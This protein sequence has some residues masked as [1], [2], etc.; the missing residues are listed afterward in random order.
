MHDYRRNMNIQMVDLKGQYAKIQNEINDAVLDA[1]KG[2]NFINGPQVRNFSEKLSIYLDGVE[3]IP[4]ANGTDALQI[5]MMALSLQPGDEI[6]VPSFTYVATAEVIAL[7][8]L[9]PVLIDVDPFNFNL[10][11]EQ[12]EKAITPKTKAI[13]PVHLFGQC[14]DME[15]ILNIADKHGLFVIEDTAQALGASYF[16]SNG[17]AMKAGT[18]GDIGCTSF[19][20]SKNLGCFGDGG[21]V[22]SRDPLLAKKI[23][24]IAN[25][26]QSEKYVHR[27]IGV[28]SRLDTIQAAVLDVKMNYLDDYNHSRKEA[29]KIYDKLLSDI[30]DVQIPIRSAYSTHVFH[31]Y[32]IQVKNGRRDKLKKHLE[33]NGIPA[34][35]YYPIPL[36]EQEAFSSI[37]KVVSSLETTKNLCE[38]VLSLPM[39][40]ELTE[41]MQQFITNEIKSFLNN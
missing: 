10:D 39:H 8:H 2:A 6:I 30:A 20:P 16:F 26:G 28:N 17:K 4:C 13:V 31:Q 15:S 33:N 19:F 37:C 7:L 21:A 34:M 35:I 5:A 29:S 12:I 11:V 24:M 38:N 25:H 22:F 32:T 14:A 3:V 9:T 18:I 23:R 1:V 41:K 40:T 36:N 27:L